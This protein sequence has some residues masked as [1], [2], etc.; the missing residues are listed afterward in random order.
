MLSKTETTMKCCWFSNRLNLYVHHCQI[1][2][3][4]VEKWTIFALQ[5][6][7]DKSDLC[8]KNKKTSFQSNVRYVDALLYFIRIWCNEVY[9]RVQ[10]S[11]TIVMTS[12]P[13]QRTYKGRELGPGTPNRSKE[14]HGCL[15]HYAIVC[16]H[17]VL[18][19]RF[20]IVVRNSYNLQ[21][22]NW[23]VSKNSFVGQKAH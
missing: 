5:G 7:I 18:Y 23:F 11:Y 6:G 16:T 3:F 4:S 20:N 21:T 13:S 8:T 22:K 12:H 2:L 9:L 19:C 14:N 1:A 15:L 17:F 10:Y